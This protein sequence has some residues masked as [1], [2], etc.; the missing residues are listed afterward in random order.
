MVE[1][2]LQPKAADKAR[3]GRH[4][5]EVEEPLQ[6]GLLQPGVVEEALQPEVYEVR[7]GPCLLGEEPLHEGLLQPGAVEEPLEPER[8]Q[9]QKGSVQPGAVEPLLQPETM[10][11]PRRETEIPVSGGPARPGAKSKT[12]A[13]LEQW[14]SVQP[15]LS[16]CSRLCLQGCA[17]SPGGQLPDQCRRGRRGR[18]PQ[19][20][21]PCH[22][23]E[24]QW[25]GVGSASFGRWVVCGMW[26]WWYVVGCGLWYRAD[27]PAG[28]LQSRPLC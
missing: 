20:I 28:H 7:G 16:R 25:A 2:L 1:E 15:P 5:L 17:G 11:E 8:D 23:V 12:Q 4:L 9:V 26:W 21:L 22:Q 13:V 6:E 10:E 3:E 27:A 18:P 24:G 14:T 19:E